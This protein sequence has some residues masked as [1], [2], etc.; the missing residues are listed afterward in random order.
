MATFLAEKDGFTL[1]LLRI[2]SVRYPEQVMSY[3]VGL[4][5]DSANNILSQN[6][7]SVLD[8]TRDNIISLFDPDE[9]PTD[10]DINSAIGFFSGHYVRNEQMKNQSK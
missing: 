8:F 1:L 5:T 3:I 2:K 10:S 6:N 9:V 7:P 4:P